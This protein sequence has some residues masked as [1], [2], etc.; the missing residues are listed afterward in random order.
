MK[1]SK[2]SAAAPADRSEYWRNEAAQA[3]ARVVVLKRELATLRAS[4]RQAQTSAA[5]YER[6]R[7]LGAAPYGSNQLASG[8]VLRFQV[9][10]VFVDA[11]LTAHSS[12]GE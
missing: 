5:R 3:A 7:I 2:V 6:L 8:N 4:E 11:D 10:D 1:T 9:L 12:R